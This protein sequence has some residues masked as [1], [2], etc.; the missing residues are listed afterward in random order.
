MCTSDFF[1][2]SEL[3]PEV[4]ASCPRIFFHPGLSPTLAMP[5]VFSRTSTEGCADTSSESLRSPNKRLN[6]GLYP[7]TYMPACGCSVYAKTRYSF[8]CKAEYYVAGNRQFAY[9]L[10]VHVCGEV[11]GVD[12]DSWDGLEV[13]MH[14]CAWYKP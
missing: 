8:L 10:C 1:E 14:I 4:W 3:A 11:V 7:C 12:G 13:G 5:R 9:A 2:T 6:T